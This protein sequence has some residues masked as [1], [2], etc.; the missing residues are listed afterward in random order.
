MK[1]TVRILGLPLLIISLFLIS[2]CKKK[3]SPPIVTTTDVTEISYITATSGGDMI[4]NGGDLYLPEVFVGIH[5]LTQQVRITLPVMVEEQ[6]N[7][8]AILPILFLIHCII[9]EPM[10]KIAPVQAMVSRYHLLP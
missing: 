9:L 4:D 10:Q 1:K 5:L 8:S 3:P 7:L 2:S 6:V